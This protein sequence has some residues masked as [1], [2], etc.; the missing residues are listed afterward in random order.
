MSDPK[1]KIWKTIAWGYRDAYCNIGFFF[2]VS[3]VSM[4]LIYLASLLM[5]YLIAVQIDFSEIIFSTLLVGALCYVAVPWHRAIL[6][7]ESQLALVH[8]RRP[9][10][11]YFLVLLPID[12]IGRSLNYFADDIRTFDESIIVIFL[13]IFGLIL[14]SYISTILPVIATED[15]SI[16]LKRVWQLWKGNRI[17]FIIFL[18]FGVLLLGVVIFGVGMMAIYGAKYVLEILEFKNTFEN[19]HGYKLFTFVGVFGLF[20]PAVIIAGLFSFV[21]TVGALSLSYAGIVQG[22]ISQDT[23]YRPHI[24][25]SE[26]FHT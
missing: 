12:L 5:V 7:N 18:N 14:I 25:I 8:I 2:R 11:L 15:K 10:L 26:K 16:P 4:C 22:A 23:N 19:M 20:T 3:W 24:I 13:S 1:F 21:A 9:E 17:R 6:L